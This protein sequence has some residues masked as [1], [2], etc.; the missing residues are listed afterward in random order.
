MRDLSEMEGCDSLI[1]FIITLSESR[2]SNNSSPTFKLLDPTKGIWTP[3]LQNTLTQCIEIFINK[4]PL[5]KLYKLFESNDDKF[6][7]LL[8]SIGLLRSD[9]VNIIK[10]YDTSV[11]DITLRDLN[12]PDLIK[13]IEGS[14]EMK[15]EFMEFLSNKSNNDI[16][17]PFVL[18]DYLASHFNSDDTDQMVLTF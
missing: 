4:Q 13:R 8:T 6:K 10:K 12:G 7:E 18:S 1:M 16:F 17:L 11:S 2:K 9:L 14:Y 15:M 3:T 5:A